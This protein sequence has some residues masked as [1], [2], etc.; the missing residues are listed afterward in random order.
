MTLW[1]LSFAGA[2]GWRGAAII[3][4]HDFF[5]AVQVSHALGLNPGGE[6]WGAEAPYGKVPD[7]FVERMLSKGDL[8]T[9]DRV[10]GGRGKL[11]KAVPA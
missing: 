10:N 5:G 3:R 11:R 9:L 7:A 1:Y 8:R 6:V 4:A 2:E